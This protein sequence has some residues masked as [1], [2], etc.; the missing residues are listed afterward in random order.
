MSPTQRPPIGSPRSLGS[1]LLDVSQKSGLA[2]P[3]LLVA[4][5]VGCAGDQPKRELDSGADAAP[6]RGADAAPVQPRDAESPQRDASRPA[7]GSVP[8]RETDA[9][10]PVD[11]ALVADGA[12]DGAVLH[13][14]DAAADAHADAGDAGDAGGCSGTT[15][16]CLSGCGGDTIVGDAVCDRDVWRC[17]QGV[18]PR[19]CP[20]GS[21]F[22]VPTYAEVCVAGQWECHVDDDAL[23]RCPTLACASCKA[24]MGPVVGDGCRCECKPNATVTCSKI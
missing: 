20:A 22:G 8:P 11:A 15:P 9:K 3:V 7:D 16:R 21:C 6:Q 1:L 14:T 4:M 5:V 13:N 2:T 17:P 23:T 19:D 12:A 24:F 10:V 18:L